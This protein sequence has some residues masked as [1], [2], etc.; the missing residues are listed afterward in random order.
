MFLLVLFF[1]ANLLDFIRFIVGNMY[2][3]EWA[4]KRNSTDK[5]KFQMVSI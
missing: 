4:I 5:Y 2:N 1:I 3:L